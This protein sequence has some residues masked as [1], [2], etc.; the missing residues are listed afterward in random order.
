M[1]NKVTV[2]VED[3]L[4]LIDGEGYTL[5]DFTLPEDVQSL[6]GSEKAEIHALQWEISN[7]TGK[8]DIEFRDLDE[9]DD[10]IPVNKAFR[11]E[12]YETYVQPFVDMWEAEKERLLALEEEIASTPPTLDEAKT[13]KL[14]EIKQAFETVSSSGYTVSSLGYRV[15]ATSTSLTDVQGLIRL[16]NSGHVSVPVMF[17]DYDNAFHETSLE[18]L[19]TLETEIT[20]HGVTVYAEKW[21]LEAQVTSAET[22]EAVQTVDAHSMSGYDWE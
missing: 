10:F 6:V 18:N 7:N 22:V 20:V 1:K 14:S 13:A 15:D 2:V 19:A 3:K 5:E 12:D 8:G 11:E 9:T 21:A 4:I 17:R 16:I